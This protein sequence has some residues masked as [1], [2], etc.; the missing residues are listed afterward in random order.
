MIKGAQRY[1]D[2]REQGGKNLCNL[3]SDSALFRPIFLR[4]LPPIMPD[5]CGNP[6]DNIRT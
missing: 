2:K 3:R 6:L 5:F 1:R 4:V